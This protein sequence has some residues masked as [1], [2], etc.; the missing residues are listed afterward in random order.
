MENY[1][2]FVV[3]ILVPLFIGFLGSFFTSSSVDTWYEQL[4]KPSFNPP[5]WLFAPV[6]TML[7]ILIGL[8]FYLV[9]KQ[10]F[11]DRKNIAVG[12]TPFN[13]Y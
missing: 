7:F 4:N 3:S 6:W 8:S 2:K 12:I 5:K 13:L 11:G 9:W 1:Q 10:N